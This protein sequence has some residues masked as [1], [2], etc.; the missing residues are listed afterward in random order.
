MKRSV[1]VW[2]SC[3]HTDTHLVKSAFLILLCLLRHSQIRPDIRGSHFH[4][5][6]RLHHWS[7]AATAVQQLVNPLENWLRTETWM[8]TTRFWKDTRPPGVERRTW[9]RDL[10]KQFVLCLQTRPT[11]SQLWSLFKQS[12]EHHVITAAPLQPLTQNLS[13]YFPFELFYLLRVW[14]SGFRMRLI[15]YLSLC[16]RQKQVR[17]AKNLQANNPEQIVL[18]VCEGV[19]PIPELTVLITA[20]LWVV[21]AAS[22]LYSQW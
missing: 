11:P 4:K 8:Q 6:L 15:K 19:W 13:T 2:A 10:N 22:S 5:S 17:A 16:S 9:R 7:A 12:H 3:H 14:T 20:F 1:R 18:Q 21:S